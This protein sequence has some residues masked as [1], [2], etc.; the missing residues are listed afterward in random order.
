MKGG[1]TLVD[2]TGLDLNSLSTIDGIYEKFLAAYNTGKL[3]VLEGV[4]NSTAVYT[5]IPVFLYTAVV[6]SDTVV[7]FAIGSNTY[8]VADDDSVTL[9]V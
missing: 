4:K 7:K 8:I 5:P 9:Q 3:A 1:Y 6:S 2:C